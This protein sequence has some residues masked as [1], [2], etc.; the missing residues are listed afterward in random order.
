M[1]YPMLKERFGGLPP[2][3]LHAVWWDLEDVKA[4]YPRPLRRIAL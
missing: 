1:S 2:R 3:G 4:A